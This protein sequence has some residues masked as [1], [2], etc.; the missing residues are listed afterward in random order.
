LLQRGIR[1]VVGDGV[2]VSIIKDNW[3][4]GY[5]AGTFTPLS[6]IPST[7]KVRFLMNDSGTDWEVDTVR[8]FFHTEIAKLF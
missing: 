7:A 1:W 8:A 3:I 6:P 4:P 2:R 5:P